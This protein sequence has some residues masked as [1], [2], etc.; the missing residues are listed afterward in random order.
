MQNEYIFYKT[1]KTHF[2]AFLAYKIQNKIFPKKTVNF[3]PLCS[4]NF[5]YKIRKTPHINI[6]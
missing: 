1:Q 2:G 3:K 4:Y 5:M 6:S